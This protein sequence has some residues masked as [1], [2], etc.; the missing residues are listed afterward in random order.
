MEHFASRY[1]FDGFGK[2]KANW[3]RKKKKEKNTHTNTLGKFFEGQRIVFQPELWRATVFAAILAIA[4]KVSILKESTLIKLIITIT[5]YS[6]TDLIGYQL[7]SFSLSS[8]CF[9]SLEILAVRVNTI[10]TG[11]SFWGAPSLK[12][13]MTSKPIKLWPPN[14]S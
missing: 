2:N 14:F 3:N 5:K 11:G 9:N 13:W 8:F 1:I 12:S 7:S 4:A 6:Q 10:H